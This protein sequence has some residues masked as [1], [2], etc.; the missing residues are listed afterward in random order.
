MV[1]AQ[2]G[3]CPQ[4]NSAQKKLCQNLNLRKSYNA[5]NQSHCLWNIER[6]FRDKG[7]C[8]KDD[9]KHCDVWQQLTEDILDPYMAD[10]TGNEKNRAD[11]RCHGAHA[12]IE[13]EHHTKLYRAHAKLHGNRQEDR[14][15]NQDGRRNIH[16][17]ADDEQ[18]DIH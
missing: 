13:D 16:E 10:A 18:D 4:K 3:R 11:W 5:L 17:H 9:E 7:N 2:K 14:R 6:K 1:Y 12:H 15:E 8:Q